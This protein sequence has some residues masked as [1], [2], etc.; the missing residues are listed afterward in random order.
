MKVP[1]NWMMYIEYNNYEKNINKHQEPMS[2]PPN[3]NH[4]VFHYNSCHLPATVKGS[5]G[6]F[7]LC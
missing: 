1:P 5:K 7:S 3:H 2:D 4:L 6:G